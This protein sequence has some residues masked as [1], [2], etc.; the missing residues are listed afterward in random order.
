MTEIKVFKI[1]AVPSQ[2]DERLAQLSHNITANF[3]FAFYCLLNKVS[4]KTTMKYPNLTYTVKCGTASTYRAFL[5]IYLNIS[6]LWLQRRKLC[7][8]I[9]KL[10]YSKRI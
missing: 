5:L 8:H 6:M 4:F 9:T 1:D 7:N 2:K 3:A 10:H